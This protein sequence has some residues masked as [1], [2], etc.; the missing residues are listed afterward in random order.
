MKKEL[1]LIAFLMNSLFAAQVGINTNMPK[2]TLEVTGKPNVIT[3]PDGIIPPSI[4]RQELINKT[5]YNN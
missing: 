5:S 4:T 2:A 3:E 1:L